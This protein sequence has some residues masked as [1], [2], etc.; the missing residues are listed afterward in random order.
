MKIDT[1]KKCF[2]ELITEWILLIFT[3][4]KDKSMENNMFNV[5]TLSPQ[6]ETK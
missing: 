1:S 3:Q 6:I 4:S 5:Y 2:S